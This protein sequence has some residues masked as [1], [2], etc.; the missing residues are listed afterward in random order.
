ME[1][2]W[3]AALGLLA[4]MVVTVVGLVLVGVKLTQPRPIPLTCQ[5]VEVDGRLRLLCE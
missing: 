3:A 1:N 5:P 4:G 2:R